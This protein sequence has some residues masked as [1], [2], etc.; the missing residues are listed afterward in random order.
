[1]IPVYL[2]IGT[3]LGDLDLNIENAIEGLKSM[4]GI[5]VEK[6]S[7]A[8]ETVPVSDIEQSDYLNVA[9]MIK[10]RMDP[11][12]LLEALQNLEK[13]L[14]RKQEKQW[15]PR[16]IDIDILLY[17]DLIIDKDDSLV[18]PHPLMH[19]RYFVLKPL[20]DIAPEAMHPVFE[21]SIKD[22][23]AEVA[24]DNE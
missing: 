3:N 13:H 10:T 6:V 20:A 17:D 16:I 24:V 19:E 22:L 23:Y 14:G 12:D 8:Y 18:I 4:P 5:T 15:A 7:K 21:K 2:G 11:N 9:V 1:M